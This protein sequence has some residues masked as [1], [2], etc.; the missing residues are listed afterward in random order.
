MSHACWQ[1]GESAQAFGEYITRGKNEKL[2]E[3]A[4]KK[5]A[6]LESPEVKQYFLDLRRAEIY[7]SKKEIKAAE[8]IYKELISKQR[9]RPEAYVH[10]MRLYYFQRN[11][12]AVYSVVQK[13]AEGLEKNKILF[14]LGSGYMGKKE[15]TKARRVFEELLR[16]MPGKDLRN[17]V[18]KAMKEMN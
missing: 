18:E 4:R 7:E 6:E 17:Q 16:K 3:E 10:L 5:I 8:S 11:L 15:F 13:V 14:A 12:D 1:R 2:K 9:S